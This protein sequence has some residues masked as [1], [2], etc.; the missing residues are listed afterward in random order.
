MGQEGEKEEAVDLGVC[1]QVAPSG[2]SRLN[3][4]S[5]GRVVCRLPIYL[6]MCK[7]RHIPPQRRKLRLLK[8]KEIGEIPFQE[9]VA[10][11]LN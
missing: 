7:H 4:C 11:I 8:A 1:V 6:D 5:Y 3:R 9:I 10:A 2:W